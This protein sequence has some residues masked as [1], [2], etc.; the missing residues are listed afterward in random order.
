MQ[1]V[2]GIVVLLVIIGSCSGGKSSNSNVSSSLAS[3]SVLNASNASASD[4]AHAEQL[5]KGL[6]PACSASNAWA[7]GDGTVN[8]RTICNGNG[9]SMDGMVSI[10]NGVVTQV[11]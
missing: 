11:K 10:K 5:L 6:P 4:V 7:T 2:I 3:T 1:W 8:I 9:R